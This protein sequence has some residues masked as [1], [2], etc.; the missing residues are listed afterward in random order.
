MK[1]AIYVRIYSYLVRYIMIYSKQFG[2]RG[3]HSVNHAI[4]SFTDLEKA[5][6]TVHYDIL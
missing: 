5:F 2:F 4:I 6:K 1:K 3:N